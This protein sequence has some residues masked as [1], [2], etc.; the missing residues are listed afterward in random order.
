[1]KTRE[2]LVDEIINR[3][4]IVEFLPEKEKFRQRLLSNDPMKIYIGAD[5][6]STSLHLSHAKNYMLLE[7]IRKLGHE[8][9]VL[10]GSFTA[11]IGDPTD[12]SVARKQLTQTDVMENVQ[13]WVQQ[14]KPLMDFDAKENPPK[15]VYNHEWLSKMTME[16]V[17]NLAS[18][19]TVQQMLE[20]DMFE[21]R[22]QEEKPIYLHEFLYPL[23]Q[24]YDS[25]ALNVEAELCGTDQIFNALVG[26]TLQGRLN[27]VEKFVVA[28][29][30]M[31][32]P[33]TGELMS[34]SRGTGIFLNFSAQDMFGAIMSQPDEMIK[35]FLVNNTRISLDE[36]DEILK[37]ENPRDAKIKTAVEIV[38]IFHGKEKANEAKEYFIKTISNKEIPDQVEE[39]EV[40]EK[41]IKL[42]ELLVGSKNATSMSDARRKVEQGGVSVDGEKISEVA[43]IVDQ[44]FD[45]KVFK[46]G[47]LGFVRVKFA[48]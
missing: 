46:I 11:Q 29:N 24:G 38:S 36:I 30:L 40:S 12:K 5:P 47:K 45:G 42:L 41:E 27:N 22:M 48:K 16:D 14:I 33:N 2:Q 43:M 10:F 9:Y 4:V 6:T 8:V 1:M 31:E 35:I 23:M 34:K 19:F 15:I 39:F 25:V 18:N 3:G 20:R 28:V 7:D 44:S 26:R 17:V 21:K 37:N 13:G 32:N